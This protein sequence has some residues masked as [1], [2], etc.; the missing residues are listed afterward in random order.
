MERERERKKPQSL[1]KQLSVLSPT[2]S[3]VK[4]AQEKNFS[5]IRKKTYPFYVNAFS[6]RAFVLVSFA[7]I[8]ESSAKKGVPRFN[9]I[10]ICWLVH[11]SGYDTF[12]DLSLMCAGAK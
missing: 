1:R 7:D 2:L 11:G 9:S 3:A 6:V 10:F 4:A 5:H 8:K 12:T